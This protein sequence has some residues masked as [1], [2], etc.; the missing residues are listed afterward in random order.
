M[1][2]ELDVAQREERVA[3]CYRRAEEYKAL[4]QSFELGRR[5]IYLSTVRQFLRVAKDLTRKQR[6]LISKAQAAGH[7]SA[8]FGLIQ[9][10]E[11]IEPHYARLCR[12]AFSA[13]KVFDMSI[14]RPGIIGL[15]KKPSWSHQ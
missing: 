1:P 3:E 8:I 12:R 9:T 2:E 7:V 10:R 11:R 15:G 5:E 13:Q 14:R 4:P 6:I